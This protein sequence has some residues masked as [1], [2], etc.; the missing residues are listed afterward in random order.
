[1]SERNTIDIGEVCRVL[2][3]TSRTLRFYEEKGIIASTPPEFGTRRQNQE[4]RKQSESKPQANRKQSESKPQ[5]KAK[6]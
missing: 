3:T 6:L 5:A 2:G 4:N 1:M